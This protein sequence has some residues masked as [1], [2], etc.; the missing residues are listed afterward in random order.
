M[1]GGVIW[2]KF[3]MKDTGAIGKILEANGLETG[4][5]VIVPVQGVTDQT[6]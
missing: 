2:K 6:I 1:G 4:T 3:P 5:D